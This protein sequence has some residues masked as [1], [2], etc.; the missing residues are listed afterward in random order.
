MK[1]QLR[2]LMCAGM[3]LPV[4]LVLAQDIHFSQAT[5]TPLLLN[6]A[7][8]GAQHNLQVFT[9]YRQQWNAVTEMYR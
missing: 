5:T 7:L 9:N 6:P 1:Q 2:L 3:L 8:A 4:S